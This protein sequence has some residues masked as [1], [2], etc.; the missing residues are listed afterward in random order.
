MSQSNP[1][2]YS[3]AKYTYKELLLEE[4]LQSKGIFESKF[5]ER[6]KNKQ[7]SI[8]IKFI[9]IKLF[10]SI[11][12]V[13][14]PILPV[15]TYLEIVEYL[16]EVEL[17]VQNLIF[18]GSLFFGL[19]F[20]LQLFNF[21]LMGLLESGMLM[22]GTIFNWFETLPISRDKLPKLAYLT[23]FRTIDIPLIVI[24]LGFP[25]IML[26]GTMN[27]LIFVVC[28]GISILNTILSFNLLI[29]F[30]EKLSRVLSFHQ[31]NSRRSLLIRMVTIIGYLVIILGSVYAIQW[32]LS[33]LDV[34]FS[35]V[36]TYEYASLT[37]LILSLIPYP[38]SPS[39]LISFIIDPSGVPIRLWI[40][41][42]LGLGLLILLTLWTYSKAK[43]TLNRITFTEHKNLDIS[44]LK[45]SKVKVKKRSQMSAFLLKDLSIATHD[46]KVFMSIIMP[47]IISCISSFSFNIYITSGPIV[48][49]RDLLFNWIGLMIFMP[50]ISNMFVYAIMDIDISGETIL[51]SL[52]VDRRSQAKA[53][54]ILL[55]TIQT[56]AVIIPCLIYI[57]N[58]KFLIFL[59][60]SFFSLPLILLILFLTFELRIHYFGRKKLPNRKHKYLIN[61]LNPQNKIVKWAFIVSFQY[62]ISFILISVALAFFFHQRFHIFLRI[63]VLAIIIGFIC[64]I[65]IFNKMFPIPSESKKRDIKTRNREEI[66][67]TKPKLILKGNSTIFTDYSGI[68]IIISLILFFLTTIW[69]DR[70]LF[71]FIPRYPNNSYDII[72]IP[73]L[74]FYNLSF[75]GLIF[76]I[77]PK[78][79]GIPNGKMPLK[80][81][82][83]NIK[84]G[85]VQSF[86]KYFMWGIIGVLTLYVF[87]FLFVLISTSIVYLPFNFDYILFGW[88]I[89]VC[90]I[91]WNELFFRGIILTI[92]QRD[93]K[94]YLVILLNALISLIFAVMLLFLFPL[95]DNFKFSDII[96]YSTYVFGI[97]MFLAYLSIKT[98]NILPSILAQIIL[99][100]IGM[101]IT[102]LFWMFK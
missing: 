18:T 65:I 85:W 15:L 11:I 10:Y 60:S 94:K 32:A 1:S 99:N 36:V 34:L 39:Y 47:I 26:I 52:P 13:I 77:I 38:L 3:L 90:Q 56:L 76:F 58:P 102:S 97:S 87:T 66:P 28:L 53:K 88:V 89:I 49:E 80:E 92:L 23:M 59:Y 95:Y 19:Y 62:I 70:I 12:F 86:S 24:I 71:L 17:F 55:M 50:I 98:N 73:A 29:L 43:Q 82:A 21:F 22:F 16:L 93:R 2:L 40:N 25:I 48:L 51:A 20:V 83:K 7:R 96:V 8:K 4:Y 75:I 72:S 61:E 35:L 9:I 69:S 41:V 5:I 68:S 63:Y 33:S 30:G 14:L 57:R 54:L 101:P 74:F 79:L 100:T 67:I 91:F 6:Y 81:Y 78:I 42:F 27:I 45:E 44:S 64:L 84:A 31:S 46:L 37:N